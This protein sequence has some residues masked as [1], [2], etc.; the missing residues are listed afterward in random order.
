MTFAIVTIALC[1]VM[2]LVSARIALRLN[3]RRSRVMSNTR[4]DPGWQSWQFGDAGG[5]YHRDPQSPP[6]SGGDQHDSG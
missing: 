5:E 4:L 1:V 3:K 2:V 6:D